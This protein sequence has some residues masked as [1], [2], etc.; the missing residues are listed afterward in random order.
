MYYTPIYHNIRDKNGDGMAN[1]EA[2]YIYIYR[3][4]WV[5]RATASFSRISALS[6]MACSVLTLNKVDKDG[7]DIER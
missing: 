5:R 3:S 4:V 6:V 2:V 1:T 7:K